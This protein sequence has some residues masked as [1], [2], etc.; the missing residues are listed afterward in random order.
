[1][2]LLDKTRLAKR[3][4]MA[5]LGAVV[6]LGLSLSI[7]RAIDK[8]VDA[9]TQNGAMVNVVPGAK[10]YYGNWET[11]RYTIGTGAADYTGFCVNPT[12]HTN[13]GQY[14][15]ILVN[16][17][18]VKFQKIKLAIYIYTVRNGVTQPIIDD[19]FQ[20]IADEG[21]RY[22]YVHAIVGYI[23]DGTTTGLSNDQLTWLNT[24]NGTLQ[25]FITTNA[26]V[27]RQAS[28]YQLYGLN[29]SDQSL[30]NIMWIE[31]RPLGSIRVMKKDTERPDVNAPQ[32]TAS[33]AGLRFV[34]K[35]NGVEK[36]SCTITPDA[37]HPDPYSCTISNL[38]YGTYTVTET[39]GSNAS[40]QV[41]V[42]NPKTVT[43]NGN[44]TTI[45]FSDRIK[46]GSVKVRKKDSK[47]QDGEC[48]TTSGHSFE[49]ITFSL[50]LS[51]GNNH[52]IIYNGRTIR[53]T[54]GE[55]P[56]VD[57]K[58]IGAT[59]CEVTF[60]D[61]PYGKYYIKETSAND[62]Y[63]IASGHQDVTITGDEGVIE[64]EFSNEPT[65]MGTVAVDGKDGDKYVEAGNS[66]TIKDTVQ[67]CVAPSKVY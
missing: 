13:A 32:G 6:L 61:L 48:K 33:F 56:V 47:M 28:G 29:L 37:D 50:Y 20:T 36:G 31:P 27:W 1:M 34:A 53:P 10:Y 9:A 63:I 12:R 41:D 8:N 14:P 15:A 67:Y 38:E 58:A 22:A 26:E 54:Q 51:S 49:G 17:S 52:P 64:I 44:D 21:I 3:I 16:E 43:V 4:L 35:L 24:I 25:G 5:A 7:I 60:S 57:S 11:H 59:G 42:N 65:S 39:Q 40:Y 19:W 45:E 30:Q 62:D 18:D 23:N 66:T 2:R 55:D 46:K